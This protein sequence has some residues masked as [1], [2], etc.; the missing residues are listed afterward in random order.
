MMARDLMEDHELAELAQTRAFWAFVEK[1]FAEGRGKDPDGLTGDE[2]HVL[3]VE[4]DAKNLLS[5][6]MPQTQCGK[7]T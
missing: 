7:S 1:E 6:F 3:S 4:F 2:V 5:L